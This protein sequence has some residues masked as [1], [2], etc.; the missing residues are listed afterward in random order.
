L[1]SDNIC[2]L[3]RI[4]KSYV[5]HA[6]MPERVVGITGGSGDGTLQR[7]LDDQSDFDSSWACEESS[8]DN[9]SGDDTL[10][11][12]GLLRDYPRRKKSQICS[13]AYP[14]GLDSSKQT[15]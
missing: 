11:L 10:K 6:Y 2:A 15:Q 4:K 3:S 1:Y 12:Q 13:Q 5:V 9:W 7:S 14:S 8:T